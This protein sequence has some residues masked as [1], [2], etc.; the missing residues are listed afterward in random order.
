MNGRDFIMPQVNESPTGRHD[1]MD[2]ELGN[3]TKSIHSPLPSQRNKIN[4]YNFQLNIAKKP[5]RTKSPLKK[6]RSETS[7]GKKEMFDKL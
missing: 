3:T 7:S 1:Y 6:K 5:E 2:I 4:N